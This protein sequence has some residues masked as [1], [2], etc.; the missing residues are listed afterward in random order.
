M[1]STPPVC[2]LYSTPNWDNQ[3]LFSAWFFDRTFQFFLLEVLHY[4]SITD[5][6]FCYPFRQLMT[7][8]LFPNHRQIQPKNRDSFSSSFLLMAAYSLVNDY[9]SLCLRN[10]YLCWPGNAIRAKTYNSCQ[11]KWRNFF[12]SE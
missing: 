7:C 1:R 8:L 5:R 9:V 12:H 4:M 3:Y 2:L 11:N 6:Q 10:K